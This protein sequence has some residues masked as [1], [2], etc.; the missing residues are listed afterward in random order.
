[1]RKLIYTLTLVVLAL[2]FSGRVGAQ[3]IQGAIIAGGNLSQVDGDEIFGFNK[4]GLN[5]GLAAV[6][7]FGQNIQLTIETVYNQ[8]GSY[9]GQQYEDTDSAGN[10]TTGEYRVKLDYLEVP[11]LVMYNDKDIITGGVGFSYARLV[12]VKEY[13]HGQKVETT[14]LNGGPYNRNDFNV[15]ADVRFR[16]Y[17]KIK[18][19][20]R[21]SYSL[22]SIRT[23]E[24]TDLRGN[25]WTRDQYN[26]NI[27]LRLIYMFNE[28]Q[29]VVT[30]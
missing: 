3:R 23:R 10:I 11:V 29:R 27:S 8:K 1:M 5:A 14:T 26:N 25:S 22:T 21:Y 16:L 18:L 15:L 13:E 30:D 17:K 6:V 12:S 4:L 7:P 28:P 20:I 19:N 2:L 9:Q 24:F